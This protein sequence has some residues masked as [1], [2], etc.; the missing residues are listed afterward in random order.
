MEVRGEVYIAKSDFKRISK[1][2]ANPRNAAAGSLRQK[3]YEE[4]KKIPLKFIA[5]SFG[6]V[7]QL[8]FYKQSQYLKLLK[9]WGF[10]TS[11]LNNIVNNIE[12]IE[13]NHKIIEKKKSRNW[14]WFRWFS[15]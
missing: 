2:F 3:N 10:E 5:Y 12:D 13:K 8:N 6:A 11:P 1:N 15:L 14:L 4:T 7:H 9:E